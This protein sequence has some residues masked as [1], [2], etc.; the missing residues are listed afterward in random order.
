MEVQ[1]EEGWEKVVTAPSN[2]IALPPAVYLL[3]GLYIVAGPTVAAWVAIALA[4]LIAFLPD[5]K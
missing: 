2:T 5:K 3:F 4:V 1:V